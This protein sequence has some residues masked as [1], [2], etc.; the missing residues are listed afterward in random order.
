M[1]LNGK[2]IVITG[3]SSGIGK[4]LKEYFST[5]NTVISLSRSATVPDI[6]CDLNS[7]ISICAAAK[8]IIERYGK[9]DVLINNAGYGLY[10]SATSRSSG[11]S[12]QTSPE[13]FCLRKNCS[14]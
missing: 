7:D 2:T 6:A 9:V 12:P 8:Q 11:N 13:R 3:A 4:A 14:P 10:G 1:K 5:D